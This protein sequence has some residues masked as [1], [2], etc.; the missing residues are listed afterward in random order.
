MFLSLNR[1]LMYTLFSLFIISILLFSFTFYIAYSSKIEKDQLL[2]IQR[3]Q[4][5]IDLLY[6]STN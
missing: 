1:K 4:E 3:N 6:R 2:S 5:Y